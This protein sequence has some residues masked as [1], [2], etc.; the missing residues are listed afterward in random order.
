MAIPLVTMLGLFAYVAY[1]SIANYNNLSRAPKL[2]NTTA[3]QTTK[4]V[5]LLQGER[6]AAVTYLSSPNSN[7]L[8]EYEAE[9]GATK[10]GSLGFAEAMNSATTK[11]VENGEEAAAI[12]KFEKTVNSMNDLRLGVEGRKLSAFTALEA[13]TEVIAQEPAIFQA[14]AGSM[15][16]STAS[17]AG[18]GLIAT[19]EARED[20]DQM[21]AALAAALAAGDLTPQER[22][23]FSQ[24]AGREQDDTLLYQALLT[25]AELA[26]FDH[27][28]D[29]P[30]T[31]SAVQDITAVQQAVEGGASLRQI[32]D[33]SSLSGPS[34]EELTSTV[35]NANYD[36]GTTAANSVLSVSNGIAAG[37]RNRVIITGAVGLAG[38]ILTLIVT[39]LL[40][41]SINRRLGLLRRSAV[42]LATEQLPSVVARL[43]RGEPVDAA[44]EAP[45]LRAGSDEIGQV[46]QAIDMVRQTAIRSAVDEARLRQGVNDMFRNLARRSQ[47]LLQRQLTVLDGMERR[48][49][50]PDVLDDLFKMDHL[51]TRMRRHAEG[52][53]ILSGAA[54]GRG[55]SNPVKLID[56]MRGAVAEVEDFARVTVSTQS[57]AALAGSAVTDLIHLLAELIENATT[58][59]PPFTQVRVT[60]EN[61]ANGFAIEIEDRGLGMTPA[62]MAELNE[63][64]L[65]PPDVNPAN[66]EQLGLFVVGQLARRHGINV[67]LR[68]S[69]YGG[70]TAVT[71]IPQRLVVDDTTPALTA[72]PVSIPS[73][74]AGFGGA[75]GAGYPTPKGTAIPSGFANG[76]GNGYASSNRYASSNGYGP[77]ANGY[78]P[79]QGRRPADQNT[80]GGGTA[81]PRRKP[82]PTAPSTPMKPIAGPGAI[83]GGGAKPHGTPPDLDNYPVSSPFTS[84]SSGTLSGS[85]SSSAGASPAGTGNPAGAT[86]PAPTAGSAGDVRQSRPRSGRSRPQSGWQGSTDIPVVTGVPVNR[87]A[88]QPSFDVFTPQPQADLDA[89]VPATGYQNGYGAGNGSGNGN[90]TGYGTY[91][92]NHGNSSGRGGG[93]GGNGAAGGGSEDFKGLPRRVRQANLAPQLRSSRGKAGSGAEV[94]QA[95]APD[96]ADLRNT[97]SAMQ[98]GWQQGR[99]QSQRDSEGRDGS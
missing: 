77:G 67:M 55:W 93:R 4:F 57:K 60:G 95:A 36:G 30:V 53:I 25:P 81:F 2:I 63:R 74:A 32:E 10:T 19:V 43:R 1:S 70:T 87:P 73:V 72:G 66:T 98:R 50:D 22:L 59:S 52:L 23:F 14:E 21:D 65:N 5:T 9:V 97:L 51:T 17:N 71:L 34:W 41:R 82:A 79:G 61:V 49:T 47:S 48:A 88:A 15:S 18:L 39:I 33:E 8:S 45:A 76:N 62:R 37:A 58:L 29:A 7:T 94:P 68:H 91:E 6:R 26:T 16:D 13:Y 90:A 38:L 24:A 64:L 44:A 99:A 78:G 12:A 75:N 84:P 54:P 20:L 35:A 83:T 80:G 92:T 86:G 69:P 3:E 42:A 11:S 40:G 56:V 31:R 96:P 85:R 28:M 27:T 89:G 46:G